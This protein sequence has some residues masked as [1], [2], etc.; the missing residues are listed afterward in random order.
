MLKKKHTAVVSLCSGSGVST[1]T[2]DTER[3]YALEGAVLS[4]LDTLD[5]QVTKPFCTSKASMQV[6]LFL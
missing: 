4:S 2:G 5:T 6:L 3:K 1:D